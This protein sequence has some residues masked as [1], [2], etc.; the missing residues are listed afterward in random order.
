MN[1][2][3]LEKTPKETKTE[4]KMCNSDGKTLLPH[5]HTCIYHKSPFYMVKR[6]LT[7]SLGI[8]AFIIIVS[9]E[10]GLVLWW[11]YDMY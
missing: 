8:H 2:L 5:I 1:V 11:K 10:S 7:D 9:F 4:Q 3:A 6:C